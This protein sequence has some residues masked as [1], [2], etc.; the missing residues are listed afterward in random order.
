M[1]YGI[2]F[3]IWCYCVLAV[4]LLV[5]Q[6]DTRVPD[7]FI[8]PTQRIRSSEVGDV[9]DKTFCFYER[10]RAPIH[11]THP[12]LSGSTHGLLRDY[13]N[14]EERDISRSSWRR[15]PVLASLVVAAEHDPLDTEDPPP[16]DTLRER[17]AV[18]SPWLGI[19]LDFRSLTIMTC[20]TT[21]SLCCRR[22]ATTSPY[23]VAVT[24]VEACAQ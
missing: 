16:F 24:L 19:R 10:G 2:L 18:Y 17:F 7:Y 6:P 4:M 20:V 15:V 9:D 13:A 11:R 5:E 14:A 22:I 1:F 12:P 23:E 8:R 3:V 21:R